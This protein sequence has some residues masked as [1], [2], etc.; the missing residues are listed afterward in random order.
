MFFSNASGGEF[1]G[2]EKGKHKIKGE[3]GL[4]SSKIAGD[5]EC[6]VER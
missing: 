2:K 1:V 6:G 5:Q 4:K 3:K